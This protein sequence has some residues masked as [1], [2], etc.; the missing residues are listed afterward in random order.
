MTDL[1]ERLQMDLVGLR[2]LHTP[3]ECASW[4]PSARETFASVA[5]VGDGAGH[6]ASMTKCATRGQRRTYHAIRGCDG[7]TRT[8]GIRLVGSGSERR[9]AMRMRCVTR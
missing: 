1:I 7:G 4:L 2:H 6:I 9:I 3:H 8:V 5:A